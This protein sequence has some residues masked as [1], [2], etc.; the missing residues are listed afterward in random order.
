[1]N[2]GSPMRAW[3]RR[4]K[5]RELRDLFAALDDIGTP[6]AIRI[7]AQDRLYRHHGNPPLPPISWAT[8]DHGPTRWFL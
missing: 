5:A 6:W 4:E 1:M 7:E 8:L 3:L 2:G